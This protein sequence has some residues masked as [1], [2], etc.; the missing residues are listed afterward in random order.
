MEGTSS[1]T[2]IVCKITSFSAAMYECITT[3]QRILK[4]LGC[5][6]NFYDFQNIKS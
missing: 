3:G 1:E 5:E 4:L 2:W 6:M